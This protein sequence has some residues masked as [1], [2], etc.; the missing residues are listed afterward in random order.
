MQR[1]PMR[2]F[3]I[4]PEILRIQESFDSRNRST[5]A[6]NFAGFRSSAWAAFD[7]GTGIYPH[8]RQSVTQAPGGARQ[9]GT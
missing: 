2:N 3:G 6:R 4:T 5:T 8:L 9:F 7:G 1:M